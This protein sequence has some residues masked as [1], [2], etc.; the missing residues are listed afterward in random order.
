ML[1][2]TIFRKTGPRWFLL[3]VYDTVLRFISWLDLHEYEGWSKNCKINVAQSIWLIFPL[4]IITHEFNKHSRF[5][6]EIL[7]NKINMPFY[8]V[9][10][11]ATRRSPPVTVW[12]WKRKIY[13]SELCRYSAKLQYLLRTFFNSIPFLLNFGILIIWAF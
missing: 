7:R 2:L 5:R 6:R 3:I 9:K 8:R 13:F 11:I 10:S 4:A 12:R 1:N